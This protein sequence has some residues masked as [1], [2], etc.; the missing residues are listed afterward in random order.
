MPKGIYVGVPIRVPVLGSEAS[1][2]VDETNVDD[3]FDVRSTASY[4]FP[5]VGGVWESNNKG[6]ASSTAATTLKAK[7]EFSSVS[8]DYSCSSESSDQFVLEVAG[9]TVD[10]LS[11]ATT[12]KSYVG[13]LKSGDSIGLTF[14]KDSSIDRYDDCCTLSKLV[15][16]A[17]EV[18][19][20]ESVGVA[21][22][23]KKVYVSPSGTAR[24]VRKAYVGVGGVA[25]LCFAS[26]P[27]LVP[28]GTIT[29]LSVPR[30]S[31]TATSVGDYALFAGGESFGNKLKKHST[32]DAYSTT[33]VHSNPTELSVGRDG[34]AA[35]SVGDYALF[36]GGTALPGSFTESVAT[37][38]AINSRLVRSNPTKLSDVP[39][40]VRAT[41]VGDYAIFVAVDRYSKYAF[42][43]A[44]SS[45]L[46]RST[47]TEPSSKRTGLAATSVG[48]YALFAGGYYGG[49]L[50]IVDAY[51]TTLVHS[52]PTEL[53]VGRSGLAATSVG[54]YALFG[55][56]TGGGHI[57][58]RVDIYNSSLV[59]STHPT[60]LSISRSPSAATSVENYALFGGGSSGEAAVDAINSRLVRSN[61]TE[62]SVG[63]YGLAATSVGDYALFGGGYT[64]STYSSSV[65]VY[66]TLQ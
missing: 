6:V 24:K 54:G 43:N 42:T 18:V 20:Y 19:G 37:V 39:N 58:S 2:T 36:G 10:R 25:R 26:E 61:P 60:G 21:R 22:Y 52:N 29:P 49:Y 44:Y 48:G 1:I 15:I 4:H 3:Y 55:G 23:A 45:S 9:V 66:E 65:D 27:E 32:V 40:S 51:S 47:P 53:S 62:L 35:T 28:Y 64:G 41:S 46:V 56:G 11:G 34:L 31:L 57:W 16:Y 59:R 38:D 50:S 8:F 13:S 30:R 63:R 14:V 5:C 33:L 7:F 12:K 17:K